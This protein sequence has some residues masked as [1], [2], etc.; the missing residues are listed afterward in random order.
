MAEAKDPAEEKGP[1]Q[2]GL[3][4]GRFETGLDP[5]MVPLNRC[6]DVDWRLRSFDVQ[7]SITWAGALARAGVLTP[8]EASAIQ[9]G[10]VAVGETLAN[11]PGPEDFPDEDIH[12]LVERLLTES[13]GPLGGKLHTG[14][15]RNDQVATDFRLWGL[16]ATREVGTSLGSLINA[17]LQTSRSGDDL[18]MPGY[19]HLQQA[20]PVPGSHWLLSRAWPLMRDLE[21]LVALKDQIGVLP[22][23]S[24]AIAGCPFTVDREWMANELGFVAVS[25]NSMDA[26]SDRDWA[27]A[28]LFASAMIGVHLSQLA[29]DL[30]LFS[31]REFGFVQ[32]GDGFTTG[33][34][35]M[36]QKRNP[37]VAELVRG[38][39]G[40]LVAGLTQLMVTL[41]GLP[42]GYNRD[43]QEDKEV[44]FRSVDTLRIVLPATTG[45]VEGISFSRQ[46]VEAAL[47]DNLLATDLA[48]YL[49]R[50]GVPFRES[51]HI[52]GALV[53]VSEERSCALADLS[54]NDLKAVHPSFEEDVKGV[55]DWTAS[56]SSRATRGGT[57]A[58]SV[59]EQREALRTRLE[60]ALGVL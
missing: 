31:S 35:L 4:G 47:D 42:P 6:L 11:A 56:V 29:E 20:Q 10:L 52:I 32:L 16:A 41:K 33:S 45:A 34:S 19:T 46:R 14:R 22:L 8:G 49:V 17:L 37:D 15:S 40:G 27:A 3:W 44:V 51:H 50:R 53:K 13:I 55:F 59:L 2:G 36:P 38:K 48:D 43:L 30:V 57:A 60:D 9:E 18:V 12:S 23:G 28:L 21:R 54:L 58:S 7:G 1:G 25:E 5:R 39:A 24:G 26:V